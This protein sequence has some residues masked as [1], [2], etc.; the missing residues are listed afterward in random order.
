[1][2][3]RKIKIERWTVAQSHEKDYWCP[4]KHGGAHASTSRVYW[5][6]YW[7]L[8]RSYTDVNEK[9]RILEIGCGPDGMINYIDECDKIAL[10]SLMDFY[11]RRYDVPKKMAW[12]KGIGESVPFRS[13]CFDVII[14]TNTLNHMW[15]P[16]RAIAD[17]SRV[18]KKRAFLLLTVDCY[19]PLVR[20]YKIIRELIGVGDRS[21]P[22]SFSM[23]Y[24]FEIMVNS[25]LHVVNVRKR[26]KSACAR[27]AALLRHMKDGDIMRLINA[28][29]ITILS[30]IWQKLTAVNGDGR[31]IFIASK[32]HVIN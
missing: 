4:R 19:S 5:S 2:K 22:H 24:V 31:F 14:S 25:G 11:V 12:I 28:M 17:I 3:P 16:V 27:Y 29:I 21:H 18:L 1:M 30:L 8:L 23:K 20:R 6:E 32:H 7:S 15:D 10:D 26:P 13:D 9:S